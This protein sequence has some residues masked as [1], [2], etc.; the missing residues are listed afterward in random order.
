MLLLGV[1][2]MACP[3]LAAA[4]PH[5]NAVLVPHIALDVEYTSS[6]SDYAGYSSVRDAEDI[7]VSGPVPD[8]D[9][10]KP[11]VWYV[12]GV[13]SDCPGPVDVWGAQ[14]G[15]GDY[16]SGAMDLVKW[17]DCF[18]ANTMELAS[19]GWPGPNEGIAI[20]GTFDSLADDEVIEVYWF[21]S[22]VYGEVQIPLDR[23]PQM[24]IVGFASEQIGTEPS[25]VDPIEEYN[26]GK[27]GFGVPGY[28]PVDPVPQE[29]ACCVDGGCETQTLDDC[30]SLGGEYQGDNTSCF[31]RNPCEP[32]M[33]TSWG[34]LKRLFR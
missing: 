21:A 14:F 1:F 2:L 24:D 8:Q 7:S 11:V 3:S 32:A 33:E 15:L 16:D 5:E 29:G 26:L 30:V 20:V 28:N 19:S 34:N 25:I 17:G 12:I 18:L 23:D 9:D 10:L 13:L 22:Y 6:I 4:G 27:L 31:P